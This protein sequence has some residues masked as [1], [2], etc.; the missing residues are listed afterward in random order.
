M[1][2]NT[3]KKKT[4]TEDE[5]RALKEHWEWGG[6][7]AMIWVFFTILLFGGAHFLFDYIGADDG[8]RVPAFIMLATLVLV[9][10]FGARQARW[11]PA[12]MLA[13]ER[14]ALIRR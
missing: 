8:V 2:L 6:R 13:I 1:M 4:L 3:Q 11:S 7:C 9:T 5:L 14:A 12:S 10:R